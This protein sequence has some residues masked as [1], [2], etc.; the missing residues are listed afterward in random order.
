M[1]RSKPTFMPANPALARI[2]QCIDTLPA[3]V[4]RALE[5]ISVRRTYRRGEYLLRVGDVCRYSYFMEAGV[6]RKYYLRDGQELTTD[7]YFPDDLALSM[8]SYTYQTSSHEAIQAVSDVV[9]QRTDHEA[10]SLVKK[11]HPALI[12]LDLLLTERYAIWLEERLLQFRTLTATERYRHLL[13]T[14][15]RLLDAVPLSHVASFL[16][17]S[18]ETLSR[19][20]ATLLPASAGS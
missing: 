18:P 2:E 9:V 14:Q 20:R 11:Q 16:S 17:M 13:T 7:L 8:A 1:I 4:Q 12:D 3:A 19:I 15:P 10:F 5:Q 6:A